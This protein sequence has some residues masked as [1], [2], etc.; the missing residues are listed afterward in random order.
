M[1]PPESPKPTPD[2]YSSKRPGDAAPPP[3]RLGLT[4]L[5][6]APDR[7]RAPP[8]DQPE[9]A[10]AGR[11]NAGKSS[12]LN[13]LS[14][15]R[16]TAKV[17]RTPGRTQLLNFFD[18]V[19]RGNS[20]GRLVDLP[21]YGY[22][23][24]RRSAQVAWQVA[25]NEYLEHREALIGIILVMDIRH[26]LQPFDHD[27]LAWAQGAGLPTL[28]LLNKADK[29]KNN[30][31][32]QTLNQ[33]RRALTDFNAAELDAICFS[34]LRGQ[35]H[36]ELVARLR[37]WLGRVEETDAALLPQTEQVAGT[38]SATALGIDPATEPDT[39]PDSKS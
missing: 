11:S 21:G 26:P 18:I 13:R 19:D 12:V 4:F 34:A 8:P 10:I 27:L 16:R 35:G 33:V 31:Q 3:D 5:T 32:A 1:C 17:S 15:N 22:A 25:V 7:Q 14:G 30:A 39:E 29:L 37:N 2:G 20:A 23:K 24:A 9:I 6:S 36:G 38:T 28:V